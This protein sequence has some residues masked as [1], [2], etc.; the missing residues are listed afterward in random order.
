MDIKIKDK[1][2]AYPD[3]AKTRLL[4]IRAI[5]LDTAQREGV[6]ELT[7][8]LKWGQ[9][10]YLVKQGS[11]VRINWAPKNP[12]KV[13]VFFNCKTTLVE[14]FRE[15]Y[16]AGLQTVGNREI[17][18]PISGHIPISVLSACVSMSLRYHTIKHLPLLGA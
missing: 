10:S 9:P 8:T 2:D 5:I 13:S 7:E 15:I 1:F 3:K 18:I 4:E 11:T 6:G 12:N 14:T 17:E 16:G